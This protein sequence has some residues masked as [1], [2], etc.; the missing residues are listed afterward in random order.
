MRVLLTLTLV[1][2]SCAFYMHTP[3]T[4]V[5]CRP[6]LRNAV[7]RGKW[8]MDTKIPDFFPSDW[9]R[10]GGGLGE[11]GVRIPDSF[12]V[13]GMEKEK[14]GGR[15]AV[16]ERPTQRTDPGKKYKVLLFNDEKNT[17]EFVIQTLV[18]FIPGMTAEKAKQVTLEAHQTGTG[19]VGI[20]MLEL[21]E[22]YSDVLRTQGL[23]SDIAEE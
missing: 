15:T 2:L 8:Q 20:W 4:S 3:L 11:G 10:R 21:A 1:Q 14:Q 23:R 16:L 7:T 5:S 17:K 9:G 6:A 12:S 19:I 22:A 18:K 13:D